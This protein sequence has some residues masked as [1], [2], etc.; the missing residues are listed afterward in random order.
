[1]ISDGS[2]E[3]DEGTFL[4]LL[5]GFRALAGNVFSLF[6]EPEAIEQV[7]AAIESADTVKDLV[8]PAGELNFGIRVQTSNSVAPKTACGHPFEQSASV[9]LDIRAGL[10]GLTRGC[11]YRVISPCEKHGERHFYAGALFVIHVDTS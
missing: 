10:S 11:P 9:V 4:K 3:T 8:T 1:M 7:K 5:W 2:L 6:E